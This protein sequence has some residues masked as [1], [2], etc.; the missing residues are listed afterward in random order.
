MMNY[1][2]KRGLM[3]VLLSLLAL[4][5]ARAEEFVVDGIKYSTDS[6]SE[7]EVTITGYENIAGDIV[8]PSTVTYEGMEYAVTDIDS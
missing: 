4:T 3:S 2:T 5:G 8:I 1:F 6:P 7:G